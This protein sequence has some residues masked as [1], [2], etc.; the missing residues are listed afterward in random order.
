MYDPSL[1]RWHTLDPL[2]EISRRWSPYTYG[3]DNPIRFIDPDGMGDEDKVKKEKPK[4]ESLPPPPVAHQ[5]ATA[6][7]KPK[8]NP[9]IEAAVAA[10]SITSSNTDAKTSDQQRVQQSNDPSS[11]AKPKE[12]L[13]SWI[14]NHIL[15]DGAL[16]GTTDMG[17]EGWH[18]KDNQAPVPVK[19]VANVSPI[20]AV[21]NLAT[22]ATTGGT[23]IY[24]ETASGLEVGANVLSVVTAGSVSIIGE[25]ASFLEIFSITVDVATTTY[26]GIKRPE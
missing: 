21:G 14:Y 2:A 3:K 17:N 11:T 16:E 5:D 23:N 15:K 9:A 26:D 19:I 12:S 8:P 1:G 6:T 25:S 20:V 18:T 22:M 24:G 10:A 13:G 7:A 4:E